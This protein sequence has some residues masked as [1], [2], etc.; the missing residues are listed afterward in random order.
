MCDPRR[1]SNIYSANDSDRQC[2]NTQVCV[3]PMPSKKDGDDRPQKN[4][5]C[6]DDL[7][8]RQLVP[9]REETE[10]RHDRSRNG[11]RRVREPVAISD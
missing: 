5:A 9:S 1:S 10:R 8:R 7:A 4:A 6:Y 3:P 2:R 11:E